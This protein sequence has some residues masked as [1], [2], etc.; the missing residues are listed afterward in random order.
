MGEG[1]GRFWSYLMS[2]FYA[3]V[4]KKGKIILSGQKQVAVS[5][6]KF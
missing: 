5:G 2:F 3:Q 1:R 6:G 4:M